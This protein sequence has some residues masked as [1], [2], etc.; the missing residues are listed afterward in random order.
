[1]TQIAI[2]PTCSDDSGQP[3]TPQGDAATCYTL[4]GQQ[5]PATVTESQNLDQQ[6]YYLY[7]AVRDA[8]EKAQQDAQWPAGYSIVTNVA[9]YSRQSSGYWDDTSPGCA[10]ALE[11]GNGTPYYFGAQT[12]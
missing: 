1:M 6:N 11:D 12:V 5:L 7:L 4:F 8:G 3:A 10:L 9:T 2:N